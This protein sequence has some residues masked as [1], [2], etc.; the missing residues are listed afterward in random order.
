MS[1]KK[2][3][4]V[5]DDRD[6]S[7]LIAYNL[8]RE[9]YDVACLYDGAQVVDFVRKRKPELIV[10]DL[11]LPEIDGIEICRTLKSDA[12]TGHIPIVM[13]TAKGEEAD[14]VV[15]LQMGADD[16]IPKP[17][18]PKVLVARIKAIGRRTLDLKLSSAAAQDIRNFGEFN[19]DL[20]KHRISYKGREVKLTSIEFDIVE[21]LSRTPGRVW[22]REQILD[23]VW[24]DG[25]FII[26]RA[27]DVHIRG[28]RK[29]LREAENYIE[30]VRGVGYRFKEV[31]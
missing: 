15:G 8:Q 16:Y 28:L 17:F 24:K 13:L 18:S 23:N 29:K 5:E 14:V 12:S 1:K 19:M 6:I 21:F 3:L 7:E 25:K 26:D 4:V 10:L 22:S 20:L 11:M 27:V 30:T 9:G 31:E 2:I